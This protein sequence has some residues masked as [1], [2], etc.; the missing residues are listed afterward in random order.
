MHTIIIYYYKNPQYFFF[1]QIQVEL[2][3]LATG[4]VEEAALEHTGSAVVRWLAKTPAKG[5]LAGNRD[6]EWWWSASSADA[7][8]HSALQRQLLLQWQRH[9]QGGPTIQNLKKNVKENLWKIANNKLLFLVWTDFN[10]MILN[11]IKFNT[12]GTSLQMRL[13]F[14]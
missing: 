12:S 11:N 10:Y 3:Q 9:N 4:E 5:I 8:L 6:T 2:P 13:S 14:L 1:Y 7:R